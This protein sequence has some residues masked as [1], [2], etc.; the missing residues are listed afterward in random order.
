M[1][2]NHKPYCTAQSE[3]VAAAVTRSNAISVVIDASDAATAD[4]V[5]ESSGCCSTVAVF[6]TSGIMH[7]HH[8]TG[9]VLDTELRDL[10]GHDRNISKFN[11]TETSLFQY[12]SKQVEKLLQLA[13]RTW[14]PDSTMKQHYLMEA[15]I[16]GGQPRRSFRASDASHKIASPGC[17][18]TGLI[19]FVMP[20][21]LCVAHIARL[22]SS[23]YPKDATLPVQAES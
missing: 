13:A 17:S 10:L 20:S 6:H 9:F 11:K 3:R 21:A 23:S 15:H 4:A 5:A 2:V 22:P 14:K 1:T 7:I 16:V 19:K 12:S 8:C 18:Q